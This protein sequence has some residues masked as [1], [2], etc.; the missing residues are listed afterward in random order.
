[1]DVLD[2]IGNQLKNQP[3]QP[4]IEQWQPEL[5]GDM[6]IVIKRDGQWIHEGGR[7]NRPALIRLFFSILRR[8]NDGEY[9]L[10]TPVEK[11]RIQVEQAAGMIT[12]MD[13][14]NE[15]GVEQYIVFTT[16]TA[17]KIL[18]SQ[19]NTLVVESDANTAEPVPLLSLRHGLSAKLTR[20]VYYR[21]VDYGVEKNNQLSVLS[22]Q[23]WFVLGDLYY[24]K[25][26]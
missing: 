2:I 18:L 4:P 7:I 11:W 10:V 17:E 20:S 19:R 6:D 3:S 1:M 9:Y 5:S 21:L 25:G 8:E 24:K 15:G 13:V 22:D 12:D 16:Y 23:C 26:P 14:F